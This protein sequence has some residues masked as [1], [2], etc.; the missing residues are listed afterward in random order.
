MPRTT[1]QEIVEG[2]E[3]LETKVE[4]RAVYDAYRDRVRELET[5]KS[6]EARVK[7][8][9]GQ[10][11][12]YIGRRGKRKTGK[13]LK[14]NVTRAIIKVDDDARHWVVPLSMLNA[15]EA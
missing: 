6:L 15:L 13:I 4:L 14:I 2:I 9:Q 11:V 1:I 12:W 10:R 5:Q 7:L 3:A 8:K